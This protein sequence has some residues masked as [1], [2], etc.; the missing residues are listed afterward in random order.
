M[1]PVNLTGQEKIE[2]GAA[3]GK[4]SGDILLHLQQHCIQC[5]KTK[6]DAMKVENLHTKFKF[7]Q[8]H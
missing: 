7:F 5:G 2:W 8:V 3:E 4:W 1:I 6:L